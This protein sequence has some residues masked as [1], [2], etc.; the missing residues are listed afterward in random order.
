MLLLSSLI[1]SPCLSWLYSWQTNASASAMTLSSGGQRSP[2]C[3]MSSD[4]LSKVFKAD[5]LPILPNWL[6]V[7]Q[8]VMVWKASS[9]FLFSSGN[10][11]LWTGTYLFVRDVQEHPNFLT[12][13]LSVRQKEDKN[14]SVTARHVNLVITPNSCVSS[15][16]CNL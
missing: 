13:I 10:E 1:S 8:P 9:G 14:I 5:C 15:V 6:V 2:K 3:S 7:S 16:E 12:E 11:I 4:E